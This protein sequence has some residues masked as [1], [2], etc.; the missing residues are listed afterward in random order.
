MKKAERVFLIEDIDSTITVEIMSKQKDII[1]CM[2]EYIENIEYDWF[3][4]SDESFSI[5]YKDGT[6][7]YVDEEYDGHKVKRNNIQSIIDNNPC[8]YAVYG[9]FEINEYGVVTVSDSEVIA[10][11]NIIEVEEA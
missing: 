1:D 11:T 7:D 4:A 3:D 9:D 10:N 8:T 2:D 5:L 6:F